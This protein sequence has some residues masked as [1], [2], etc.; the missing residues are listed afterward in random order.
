MNNE[1]VNTDNDKN[2]PLLILRQY[3]EL[4][5]S[6]RKSLMSVY[7][8]LRLGDKERDLVSV[9]RQYTE[10]MESGKIPKA[11]SINMY[12]DTSGRIELSYR[13]GDELI[14][15]CYAD[16]LRGDVHLHTPP[17]RSSLSIKSQ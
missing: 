2:D 13:D 8:A 11:S 14:T 6:E 7:T 1:D 3:I 12:Q 5:E 17:V 15:I 10:L 16:F 4:L 9:W